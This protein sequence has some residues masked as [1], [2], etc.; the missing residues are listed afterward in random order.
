MTPENKSQAPSSLQEVRGW[1][2]RF[3][4]YALD[5]SG[6]RRGYLERGYTDTR[7]P[8]SSERSHERSDFVD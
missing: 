4:R 6:Q 3:Q 5:R 7:T 1:V 2:D 8:Y